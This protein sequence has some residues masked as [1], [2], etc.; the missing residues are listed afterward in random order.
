MVERSQLRHLN[1]MDGFYDDAILEY[2]GYVSEVIGHLESTDQLQ[3]TVVVLMSDHGAARSSHERVPLIIKFPGA[4]YTG[5]V[6]ENV[7][8]VDIAPTLVEF[9]GAI[10]PDWMEGVSMLGGAMD[11]QR[12]IFS[13]AVDFQDGL[14]RDGWLGR[15]AEPAAPFYTM[16][17]LSMVRCH[18]WYLLSLADSVMTSQEV[19]GHTAP[20][21]EDGVLSEQEARAL[22]VDHLV[23]HGYAADGLRQ[24]EY[25]VSSVSAGGSDVVPCDDPSRGGK[26]DKGLCFLDAGNLSLALTMFEGASDE[27]PTSALA[28]NNICATRNLMGQFSEGVLACTKA[29]ELRPAYERASNNLA[30]AERELEATRTRAQEAAT[31]AGLNGNADGYLAAGLDYYRIGDYAS[32]LEAWRLALDLQPEN[33]LHMNNVGVALIGLKN[34]QQAI[35]VLDA[36]VA[37]AP[38]VSRYANNRRWAQSLLDGEG[39][40]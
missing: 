24:G 33:A 11:P 32:S 14:V 13:A 30:W 22:I 17:T 6:K 27:D 3:D 29:L 7:Q 10:V 37:I 2:D 18:T 21:P 39:Q 23:Q 1:W 5:R 26:I 36:A 31:A 9:L 12:P 34:Y 4:S 8:L 20:C 40:D 19:E 28:F 25:R 16:A 15:V 38:G 35:V